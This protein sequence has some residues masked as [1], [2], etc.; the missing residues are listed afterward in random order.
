MASSIATAWPSP[1]RF[2][3]VLV[4]GFA[5]TL[6]AVWAWGTA[7]IEATLPVTRIV[8]GWIDERFSILFLGIDRDAQDTIVR[9]RVG[10]DPLFVMAGRVLEA[11]PEGWLEVT[12]T[13][14]AILQPLTIAPAIALAL[15][16]PGKWLARCCAFG[17]AATLAFLFMLLDL[18]LTLFA[19]VWDMMIDSLEP[20]RTPPLLMW[21]EFL[22]AGG[23]LG[24]A[25]ML[26]VTAWWMV[27]QRARVP[28]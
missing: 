13:T 12:T 21:H 11:S 7:L 19:Y 4:P 10:L 17:L 22:H 18:P 3:L 20:G 14:G 24:V 27:R 2:A 28:A 8:L 9:L 25:L 15:P 26:G 23:R 1:G 5:L 16:L 6:A